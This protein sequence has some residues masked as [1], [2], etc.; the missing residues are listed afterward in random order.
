MARLVTVSTYQ[1][2]HD[3]EIAR[4]ALEAEGIPAV[5][6]DAHATIL[7]HESVRLQVPEEQVDA[8]DAVLNRMHGVAD[9]EDVVPPPEPAPAPNVCEQCGSPD[10]ARRQKAV[11]FVIVSAFVIAI[12]VTQG[13]SIAAFFIV[14]ALAVWTLVAASWRCRHCGHTW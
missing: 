3:A 2:L 6:A 10:V 7:L 1:R 11:G 13:Q 5:V 14:L 9:A 12:G 4:M 8:A